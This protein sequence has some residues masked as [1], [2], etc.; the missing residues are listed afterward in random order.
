MYAIQLTKDVGTE[1]VSWWCEGNIHQTGFGSEKFRKL[2]D[3]EG[4]AQRHFNYCRD[5]A[6]RHH[7]N[8]IKVSVKEI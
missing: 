8:T 4:E 1:V 6:Y 3:T 7:R 2:Y 5:W